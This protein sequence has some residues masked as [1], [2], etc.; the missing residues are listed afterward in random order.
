MPGALDASVDPTAPVRRDTGERESEDLA[1][2][3]AARDPAALTDLFRRHRRRAFG[4]A[5][6]VLGDGAAAEDAVQ[7]AFV[8]LWERG[9]RLDPRG[10]RVESLLMTIVHRRAVD[11]VRAR[12][13]EGARRAGSM[14]DPATPTRAEAIADEQAADLFE[15][16]VEGTD[17]LPARLRAALES[18][19]L[20][21]R[22]AVELAYF[23]GLTHRAIAE[24]LGLP[25]G[26]VKSRLRLAMERLRLALGVRAERGGR[27]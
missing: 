18:L 21:Q 13:R 4:L 20:E 6:R 16:L 9:P 11:L 12:S 5:Y 14:D 1:R 7:A 10:G 17:D 24:R 25:A 26:T 22:E 27:P 2:R 23:D 15:R 3:L 8:D 19:P